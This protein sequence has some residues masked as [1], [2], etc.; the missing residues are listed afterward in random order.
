[1]ETLQVY[2]DD[3]RQT[4]QDQSRLFVT[5]LQEPQFLGHFLKMRK[6][7]YTLKMDYLFAILD[8]ENR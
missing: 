8:C 5:N 6:T 1:M 4:K 2:T 7:R 3:E